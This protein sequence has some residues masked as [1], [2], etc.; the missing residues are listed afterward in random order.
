M[1]DGREVELEFASFDYLPTCIARVFLLR[2]P[3]GF[4]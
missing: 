1:P 4:R 2:T 3:C